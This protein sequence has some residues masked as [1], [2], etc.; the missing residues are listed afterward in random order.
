MDFSRCSDCL[1]AK[2]I[3]TNLPSTPQEAATP[4]HTSP[5]GTKNNNS[6]SSLVSLTPQ[7]H[8]HFDAYLACFVIHFCLVMIRSHV[9]SRP[10]GCCLHG[11]QRQLSISEKEAS[12]AS[13]TIQWNSQAHERS[14]KMILFLTTAHFVTNPLQTRSIFRNYLLM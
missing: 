8:H 5:P 12:F 2:H 9:R 1:E 4:R 11:L 6:L 10:V 14:E 7:P 13:H 3:F